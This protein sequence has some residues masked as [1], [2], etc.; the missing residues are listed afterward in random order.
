MARALLRLP[1]AYFME[2]IVAKTLD[3][4]FEEIAIGAVSPYAGKC[5]KDTD[6]SREL[7]IIVIAIRRKDGELTSQPNGDTTINGGDRLIVIGK[8]EAVKA[9]KNM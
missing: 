9:L 7:S 6:M 1:I 2:S 8:A 4:V 5:M 3:Q